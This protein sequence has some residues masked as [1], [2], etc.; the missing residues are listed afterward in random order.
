MLSGLPQILHELIQGLIPELTLT[1]GL[2][3]LLLLELFGLLKSRSITFGIALG[4][5]AAHFLAL[6]LWAAPGEP[7]LY[8]SLQRDVLSIDFQRIFIV[9]TAIT[10]LMSWLEPSL[11]RQRLSQ[12]LQSPQQQPDKGYG[13]FLFTLLASLLA[14]QLLSMSQQLL[15]TFIALEMLAL[16]S[17]ILVHFR[18]APETAEASFKYLLFGLLSSGLM[19]YGMSWLYGLSGALTYEVLST[20]PYSRMG[21]IALILV[22]SGLFFKLSAPP[23]HF[24]APDV[25]QASS[26]PVAAFLSVVTKSAGLL[27][28]LR[29]YELF[30]AW[31][32]LQHWLIGAA[33]IALLLGNTVALWQTSSKRL[34]AYSSVS[35]T[36]FL[37]MGVVASQP[38]VLVFYVWIYLFL[39]FGAFLLVQVIEKETGT[40]Q[41]TAFSGWGRRF[42]L[43]GTLLIVFMLGLT[44]LP[45]TAGLTAKFWLFAALWGQ[46]QGDPFLLALLIVGVLSSVVGLFYYLKMP[47][48]AFFRTLPTDKKAPKLPKAELALSISLGLLVVF[49]LFYNAWL[50]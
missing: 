18:F 33:L 32:F 23:F 7:L 43:F 50:V 40:D 31:P 26:V 19:L 48:Y 21:F 49:L 5:L 14:L 30:A 2:L 39:N 29:F 4:V 25:Y 45:P 46:Y 34:L 20:L 10:L 35:H 13:E 37:L 1:L 16:G 22:L 28:L 44:G 47:F 3:L 12:E 11:F 9:G 8:Q 38:E 17:Y 6:E 41:L 42:P 24:W 27:V 15:L 36:G